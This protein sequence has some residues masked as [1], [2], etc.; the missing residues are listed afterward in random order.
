MK[1]RKKKKNQKCLLAQCYEKFL[2]LL[3]NNFI[4]PALRLHSSTNLDEYCWPDITRPSSL[5]NMAKV[6][7]LQKF[8]VKHDVAI[9]LE[10]K[11]IE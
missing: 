9:E 7:N 10:D 2:Y 4:V 1:N 3:E 5:Q 11:T 6:K 8:I